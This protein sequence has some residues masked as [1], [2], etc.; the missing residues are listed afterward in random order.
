[1]TVEFIPLGPDQSSLA[2]YSRS[3]YGHYDFG[4]NRN[5]AETWLADLEKLLK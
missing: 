5:R 4:H 3:R 2:I 1:V